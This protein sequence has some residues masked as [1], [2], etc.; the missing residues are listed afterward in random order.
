[1]LFFFGFLKAC[2][3]FGGG[4][5]EH[6]ARIAKFGGPHDGPATF[7]AQLYDLRPNHPRLPTSKS[8]EPDSNGLLTP[9]GDAIGDEARAPST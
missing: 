2:D 7:F 8:P 9:V 3:P 6:A 4:R 1:M 5:E